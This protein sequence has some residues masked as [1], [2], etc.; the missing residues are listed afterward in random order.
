[1][2]ISGMSSRV[3]ATNAIQPPD[4]WIFASERMKGRTPR[5]GNMLAR[6]HLRGNAIKLGIP[7]QYEDGKIFTKE[8]GFPA[9]LKNEELMREAPF[10][11]WPPSHWL[12]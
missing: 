6:D 3:E 10:G 9:F 7:N 11:L 8:T 12:A 5:A 2:R 4:H 1:V